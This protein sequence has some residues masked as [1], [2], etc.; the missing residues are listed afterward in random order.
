LINALLRKYFVFC[1]EIGQMGDNKSKYFADLKR[2]S[3]KILMK[4]AKSK[5]T[6]LSPKIW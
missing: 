2:F 6:L 3:D 1:P 5:K 4:K